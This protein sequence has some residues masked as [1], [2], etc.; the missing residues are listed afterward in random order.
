EIG[1]GEY[2]LYDPTAE[3][4]KPA[5]AGYRLVHGAYDAIEPNDRGQLLSERLRLTL[6]LR[7]GDLILRDAASGE[8][9]LTPEEA[10]DRLVAQVE[11][12][13][14]QAEQRRQQAE[15]RSQQVESER[16]ALR[17]E[18]ESLRKQLRDRSND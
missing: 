3:Y 14:Q 7:D 12:R 11:W 16:A 15:L 9:P 8:E 4:L 13:S 17:A 2:F 6:E 10:A 1:V 5:H 18:L